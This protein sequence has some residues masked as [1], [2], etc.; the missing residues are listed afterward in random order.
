MVRGEDGF[1]IKEPKSEAGI[2][3]VQ[4]GDE[5]VS[6]LNMAKEQYYH[7]KEEY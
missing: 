5:V 1:I 6:V 7:D 3:D 4:I 2:R